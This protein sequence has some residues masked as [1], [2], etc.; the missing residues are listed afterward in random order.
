VQLAP[1]FK[2]WL[3]LKSEACWGPASADETLPAMREV[4]SS[5]AAT[6]N[7]ATRRILICDFLVTSIPAFLVDHSQQITLKDSSA[8]PLS[9]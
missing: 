2:C 6:A 7:A 9:D 5:R 1:I 4:I 8:Q 3:W